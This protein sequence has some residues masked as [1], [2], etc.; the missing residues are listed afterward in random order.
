MLTVVSGRILVVDDDPNWGLI[1]KK[2]LSNY[3][4][5]VT[6]ETG[7]GALESIEKE[8]FDIVMLD[9]VLPDILGIDLIPAIRAHL[10]HTSIYVVSG[11]TDDYSETTAFQSG[12]ER[13][14]DKSVEPHALSKMVENTLEQQRLL[15]SLRTEQERYVRLVANAPIG[16]FTLNPNNLK[17]TFVNKFLLD[18]TGY[19]NEDLIGHSPK[20]FVIPEHADLLVSRLDERIKGS[21]IVNGERTT[22]RFLKKDGSTIDLQ[23]ETHLVEESGERFLEGTARDVTTE[24][25]VAR[26]QKTVI[27][28]GQSIVSSSNIDQMLQSVLDAIVEQS[29]FQR[30]VASLYDL[31]TK[32]PELGEVYKTLA[33][34]LNNEEISRLRVGG[35]LSAAQR[36]LAF[37]EEFRMGDAYYIPHDKVPW[38]TELGLSGN[39]SIEGWDPNDYLFIPLRAESGIIGHISIDDPLDRSAPTL[40]TLQPVVALAN[41]AALAVERTYRFAQ[42][43]KQKQILHGLALFS[44]QLSSAQDVEQMCT[45]AANRLEEDMG[46]DF[47]GIWILEGEELVLTS[48]ASQGRYN[49]KHDLY[50]GLRMH[51]S[52]NGFAR[53]AIKKRQS[54]IVPDVSSEDRYLK[55]SD[56]TRSEIDIPIISLR[57]ALGVISV[58]SACLDAFGV[59]DKEIITSLANQLS[60]AISNLKHRTFLFQIHD[61]AHMLV[62]ATSIEEL[63]SSTLDFI[64]EQFSMQQSIILLREGD[65]LVVRGLRNAARRSGVSEGSYI[66]QGEGIVGWVMEHGMHALV[67]D[68]KTDKRYVEGFYGTRSELAVPVMISDNVLGVLNIESPRASFFDEKDRRLL[69]AAA[70]QFAVALSNLSAQSKLREQAVR[71]PLTQL[72]NRHYLNEVIDGELDRADRYSREITL[73]MIDINGF[74]RVNNTLGHLKG[75]EVLQKVAQVLT[76]S[77]RSSDRVI[78]YGGDEFLIFM[79]ETV[80]E[81]MIVAARLKKKVEAL[82]SKLELGNLTIGLSIGTYTRHPGDEHSVEEIL[83]LA[84]RLMY[85]N[86]RQNYS[87]E[88]QNDEYRY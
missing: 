69:A 40:Q 39:V 30:A 71:D 51:I 26:L 7:A 57:E 83:A 4:E 88:I 32:K 60:V 15:R 62:G 81:E 87:T 46:Y 86:K 73:M 52:G 54:I 21:L 5:V 70:A 43:Q 78:R 58:E 42:L 44:Q 34:G 47:L 66:E 84:D 31:S 2:L 53:W 77:V 1:V 24:E 82:P 11:H 14:L 16:V 9:I 68:V 56:L 59:Q 50:P 67:D 3:S 17:L 37:R 19:D 20:E 55:W 12:A 65:H 63:I 80:E 74:R 41:L 13:Y 18:I 38:S 10:P 76:Q 6:V 33:A 23:V 27:D 61:L 29:G 45:L 85:E 28:L 35:T 36:K 64:G 8:H 25:R 79:P 49:G 48:F 72:F 22:Y 75:D